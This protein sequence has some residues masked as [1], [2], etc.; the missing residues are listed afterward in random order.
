MPTTN[1]PG[2]DTSSKVRPVTLKTGGNH[3]LPM[4]E[5]WRLVWRRGIA[6]Q[7][8][9]VALRVLEAALVSD[10]S[11]IIQGHT[12]YPPP[13]LPRF[14]AEVVIAADPIAYMA[15]RGLQCR[16]VGEVEEW[17]VRTDTACDVAMAEPGALRHLHNFIDD[18]PREEMRRELLAE[19]RRTLAEGDGDARAAEV[20]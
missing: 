5:R 2:L 19:V 1:Q 11:E 16:T 7:M 10:A 3:D 12:C 20:R 18:T 17:M 6:P 8:P 4:V 14:A 13:V 15:W 9:S